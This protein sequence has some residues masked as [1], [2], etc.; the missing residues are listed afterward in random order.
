MTTTPPDRGTTPPPQAPPWRFVRRERGRMIAGVA[1]GMADAFHID[2]VVIRVLWVIAA[3]AGGLGVAAYVIC[4]LAFPSDRHA[5]P[6]SRINFPEREGRWRNAGVIAAIV[7]IGLGLVSIFG[8]L[9]PPFRHGGELA[10]ATL[11]IGGG[12]AIL[13]FRHDDGDRPSPPERPA[14]TTAP[15]GAPPPE[16]ATTPPPPYSQ[17]PTPPLPPRPPTTTRVDPTRAVA[18]GAAATAADP[19]SAAAPVPHAADRQPAAARRWHRRAARLRGLGA[20]DCGGRPRV[21]PHPRRVRARRLRVARH[22]R[23]D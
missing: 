16:P 7:L 15:T 2:V 8:A 6:L 14:G 10:W 3:L 5:A 1:T 12:A 11:L 9:M 21:G 17:P 23:T 19:A 18:G 20:P 13:L 4:W 22:A